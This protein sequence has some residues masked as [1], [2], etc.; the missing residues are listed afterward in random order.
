MPKATTIA[1]RRHGA[2]AL[3]QAQKLQHSMFERAVV[4]DHQ[5]ERDEGPRERLAK[6]LHDR[7]S[8]RRH[9]IVTTGR[10]PT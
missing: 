3:V 8:V 7:A 6:F 1:A 2:S 10:P 4:R 5:D 9:P